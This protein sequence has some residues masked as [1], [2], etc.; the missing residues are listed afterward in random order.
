MSVKA[1]TRTMRPVLNTTGAL[2]LA[3]ALCGPQTACRS[4][5]A[6]HSVPE[7]LLVTVSLDCMAPLDGER[8]VAVPLETELREIAGLEILEAHIVP[9]MVSVLGRFRLGTGPVAALA[10]VEGA[11]SRARPRFPAGAEVRLIVLKDAANEFPP[12]SERC[13]EIGMPA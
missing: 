10:E 4:D 11:V 12:P 2:I 8:L 13:A 1:G 7:G 3:V 6:V 9:G 5:S